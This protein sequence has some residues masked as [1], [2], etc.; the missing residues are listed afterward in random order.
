MPKIYKK[1]NDNNNDNDNDIMTSDF[2][3]PVVTIQNVNKPGVDEIIVDS[4]NIDQ[5][6]DV[7]AKMTKNNNSYTMYQTLIKKKLKE[8]G[9][10]LNKHRR[11]YV[12]PTYG[13]NSMNDDNE[14]FCSE[15]IESCAI[16]ENELNVNGNPESNEM[17]FEVDDN[18][19]EENNFTDD[20]EKD[21]SL[22][23]KSLNENYLDEIASI[24][25]IEEND[26]TDTE[27]DCQQ[28]KLDFG[29]LS[30]VERYDYYK[31]ILENSKFTFG[32]R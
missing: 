23:T 31:T 3:T 12:E 24:G 30:I 4:M 15:L 1:P 19:I 2:I 9:K 25:S 5:D 28:G 16:D 32:E 26:L 27:S 20:L 21:K 18:K 6:Q 13:G 14:E 8:C 29:T 17:E 7:E 11:V 22:D 10:K